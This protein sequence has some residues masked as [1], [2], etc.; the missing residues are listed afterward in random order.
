MGQIL[1]K[2][3]I[4]LKGIPRWLFSR[5]FKPKLIQ[6]PELIF[7]SSNIQKILLLRHDRLGDVLVSIPIFRALRQKLPNTQLDILLSSKNFATN[8]ALK[9]YLDKFYCYDKSLAGMLKLL[10]QIR[11]ERYDLVVDLLDNA[12]VTSDLFL[13]LSKSKN[14]VG[15]DKENRRNYHYVVPLL[16][17]HVIHIV[18]RISQLLLPFGIKPDA[19]D[20]TLEY[21]LSEEEIRL[22]KERLGDKSNKIRVGINLSG[23]ST[24]KYWGKQNNIE[25]IKHILENYRNCEVLVFSDKKLRSEAVEI[26]SESKTRLAPL[27]ASFNEFASMIRTCDILLTPDTSVVHLASAWRQ[28]CI[29]LYSY[30]PNKIAM[31]WY[32]YQSNY[33]AITTEADSIDAIEINEVQAAFS[34]LMQSLP[35]LS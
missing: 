33:I 16:N 28:P 21:D 11:K 13:K 4:S 17:K 19:K 31:P 12:S 10:K 32:P 30:K 29:V 5:K 3:E 26:A 20:L 1:K 23:S 25:F 6:E 22:G 2:F 27:V 35:N 34:K 15:I 7:T 14:N 8:S 18:E 24:S 9:K